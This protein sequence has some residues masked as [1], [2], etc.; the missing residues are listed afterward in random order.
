MTGSRDR[1]RGET[2]ICSPAFGPLRELLEDI[3]SERDRQG[4]SPSE[5]AT[6]VSSL[7]EPVFTRLRARFGKDADSLADSV[8]ETTLLDDLTAKIVSH[9]SKAVLIEAG[10]AFV[11][12][13]GLGSGCDPQAYPGLWSYDPAII[14]AVLYRDFSRRRDDVT[15]VAA[16]QARARRAISREAVR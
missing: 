13:D 10:S 16:T 7:K 9:W 5:T 3:S 6:F 4:Y 11:F 12:S 8:W 2:E 14:A 15:V 1:L